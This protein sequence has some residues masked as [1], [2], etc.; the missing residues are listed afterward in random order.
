MKINSVKSE[1][2]NGNTVFG[3][4]VFEFF[5]PGL[6]QILHVAG[7]S[8]VILIWNIVELALTLLKLRFPSREVWTL[9]LWFVYQQANII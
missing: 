9:F 6:C 7:A 4:M 2:A 8:F 5:T 1:L 3:T